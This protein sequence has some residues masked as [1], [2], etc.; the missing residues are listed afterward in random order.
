MGVTAYRG[1]GG[2]VIGFS[3]RALQDG[4]KPTMRCLEEESKVVKKMAGVV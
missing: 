3:V 2:F 4:T 1:M